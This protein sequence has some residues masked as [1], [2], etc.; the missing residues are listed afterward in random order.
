MRLCLLIVF[1]LLVPAIYAP[2]GTLYQLKSG[3]VRFFS[4]ARDELIDARSK[5]LEGV[6]D[7]V[8][9]TFAFRIHITSF[10][11]FNNAL[12]REHFNENYMESTLFPDATFVGRIIEDVD[13]TKDGKYEVR[14]KGKMDIHGVAQERIIKSTITVK[15][16]SISVHS[17]FTVALV[18]HNLK[19]PRIVD[20]K[21]AT[22][23]QVWVD[24]TF[25]P[26]A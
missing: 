13:F 18:D 23:I 22:E 20:T 14:A 21:L 1:L 25:I 24:A 8:K 19:I 10:A 17:E 16:G 3:N 26:K 2:A 15:H 5:N 9:K 12:Q 6:I 4:K 7:P 11:G